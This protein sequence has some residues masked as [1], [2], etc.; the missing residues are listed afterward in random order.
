ME[1]LSCK[2]SGGY[3]IA[4]QPHTKLSDRGSPQIRRHER[5]NQNPMFLVFGGTLRIEIII[6][7]PILTQF[8]KSFLLNQHHEINKILRWP[9]IFLTNQVM[10]ILMIK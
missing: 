2:K 10:A 1:G 9:I 4:G 5:S 7:T 6:S 8:P 3:E